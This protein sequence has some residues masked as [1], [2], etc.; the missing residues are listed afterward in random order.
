VQ[1]YGGEGNSFQIQ[2]RIGLV[3]LHLDQVDEAERQFTVVRELE[4][5]SIDYLYGL[6]GLA[7][8]ALKR[9]RIKEAEEGVTQV[10]LQFTQRTTASLLG[11]LLTDAYHALY[12]A[13]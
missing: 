8:V 10:L 13:R 12:D 2:P 3:H 4:G 1:E 9:G 6:Y 5:R 11:R 7:L